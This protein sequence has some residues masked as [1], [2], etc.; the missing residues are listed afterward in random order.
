MHIE[1]KYVIGVLYVIGISLL[2]IGLKF[3]KDYMEERKANNIKSEM[4]SLLENEKYGEAINLIQNIDTENKEVLAL[5]DTYSKVLVLY[6]KLKRSEGEERSKILNL[7]LTAY[8]YVIDQEVL[9]KMKH[10]L[11]DMAGVR[12]SCH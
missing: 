5:A 8:Y 1:K 12:L 2:L 4:F 11:Y 7:L 10:E 3:T 6:T 9:H